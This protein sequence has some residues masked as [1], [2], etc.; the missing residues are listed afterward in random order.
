LTFLS[1]QVS[2]ME[3]RFGIP[4][5]LSFI[6]PVT[7]TELARIHQSMKQ[8]RAHD[9]TLFI[10]KDDG[11]I[12]IAKPFYQPGLFRAPSGGVVIGEDFED[13]AKREAFEETGVEI[14]LE[15]YILRIEVRFETSTDHIDWVSHI[16]K[17]AYISG[18]IN[19]QDKY[20]IS[21][22][23]LAHLDEIP[24][25]RKIMQ[26]SSNGGLKYRVFLTDEALKRL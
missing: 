23:R 20:E 21:A 26:E 5:R 16:F 22:A 15:R 8:G 18:E 14:K 2:E 1:S 11:Y 6:Q 10:S 24:K 25:F 13:G 7:E 4:D 19:P 9:I 3:K 12:F 17:A